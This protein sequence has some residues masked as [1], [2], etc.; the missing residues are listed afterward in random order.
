[1]LMSWGWLP[2]CL[3][4]FLHLCV[5][6]R[7]LSNT[8]SVCL[9]GMSACVYSFVSISLHLLLFLDAYVYILSILLSVFLFL[10]L[11]VCLYICDCVLR[12]VCFCVCPSVCARPC[13]PQASFGCS[14]SFLLPP[15]LCH[16]GWDLWV[17]GA[18]ALKLDLE[19]MLHFLWGM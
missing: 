16:P 1:M 7:D 14:L 2:V 19:A 8:A 17:Q 4:I 9:L 3:T 10:H 15:Q 6:V 18:L 5:S 11:W 12:S 13:G